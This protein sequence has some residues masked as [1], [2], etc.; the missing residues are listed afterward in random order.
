MR[1]FYYISVRC[2]LVRIYNASTVSDCN[3]FACACGVWQFGPRFLDSNCWWDS[4]VPSVVRLAGMA[5]CVPWGRL[6]KAMLGAHYERVRSAL[7]IK[8]VARERKH[9]MGSL[10]GSAWCLALEPETQTN[11][12]VEGC[13]PAHWRIETHERRAQAIVSDV[14]GMLFAVCRRET[15]SCSTVARGTCALHLTVPAPVTV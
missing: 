6:A 1:V 3:A 13:P 12:F 9:A 2:M 5:L 10:A 8:N 4:C 14:L 11:P 15:A 7:L